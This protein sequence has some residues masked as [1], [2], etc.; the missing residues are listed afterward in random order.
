M[1]YRAG[2]PVLSSMVEKARPRRGPKAVAVCLAGVLLVAVSLTTTLA[3]GATSAAK[4]AAS[5]RGIGA[6]RTGDSY[7]R[8]SNYGR[9]DYLIIGYGD[10][11][12]A[13]R[14]AARVLV[15]KAAAEVRP[16]PNA[17]RGASDTGVAYAEAAAHGWLLHDAS[18]NEIR[19]VG[20]AALGDV[21]SEPFQRAW[22][23]N[24]SHFLLTHHAG[25]VF[26]DNVVCSLGDLVPGQQVVKYPTAAAWAD[27]EASFLAYV[28]PRLKAM[29]LYVAINAYCAG[30]DN[31][32]ANNGWWARLAPSVSGEA[33]EY[34]E[35]NP[36]DP[37]QSYFNSPTTSWLGN[38]LGKLNVI[39]V[40]QQHG[41]DGFA[42]TA[43]TRDNTSLMTYARASY[44]LVWNGRGGGFIYNTMDGSDPWNSA[45]TASIGRPVRS[46]QRTGPVFFR[47]Y[48]AG[49]VVVNPSQSAV[50][51]QLPPGLRT[52]AGQAAG[53]S[54]QLAP[55]TAAIF[56]R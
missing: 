38:W 19:A 48:T 37:T 22:L 40:A 14:T 11:A 24:V 31:G 47:R 13:T 35:Q 10:V 17:D 29:G 28:G 54:V 36:N 45:W 41:R 56:R 33:T 6:V 32:S 50:T 23:A 27:A 15:Y 4:R 53:S 25:G 18:G 5:T 7:N 42:I 26:I 12:A 20:D 39:R 43:G 49:Y 1:I 55:T 21:G 51:A 34:F 44:L 46:M 52:V 9:Y 2:A 3:D 16:S 8:G 30:A